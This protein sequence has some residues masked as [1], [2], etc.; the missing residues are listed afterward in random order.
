[1]T[2]KLNEESESIEMENNEVKETG[3][4]I[5]DFGQMEGSGSKST[6]DVFT[7]ITDGKLLFNLDNHCDYKLN[8]CNLDNF[9]K[10]NTNF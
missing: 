4:M 10:T 9:A 8:D 2:K 1:M 3:L 5:K 7:T 6:T